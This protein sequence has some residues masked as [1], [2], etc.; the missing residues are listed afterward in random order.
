VVYVFGLRLRSND[1]VCGCIRLT[2][3][4]KLQGYAFRKNVSV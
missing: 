1:N 2:F 4:A 3:T